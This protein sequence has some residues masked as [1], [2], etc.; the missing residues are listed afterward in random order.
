[1][2]HKVINGQ[3]CISFGIDLCGCV[4]WFLPPGGAFQQRY[5]SSG[6]QAGRTGSYWCKSIDYPVEGG[7]QLIMLM[8]PELGLEKSFMCCLQ[9]KYFY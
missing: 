2:F 8:Y 5:L 3:E 1:M 4:A 6:E 7:P 9:G